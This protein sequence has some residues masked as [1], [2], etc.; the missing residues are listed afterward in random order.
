LLVTTLSLGIYLIVV[1]PI[2]SVYVNL[3]VCQ[4]PPFSCVDGV[5]FTGGEAQYAAPASML[6]FPL[7][8]LRGGRWEMLLLFVASMIIGAIASFNYVLGALLGTCPS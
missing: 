5:K 1:F 4:L 3:Q 7:L 8:I 6:V 2:Y